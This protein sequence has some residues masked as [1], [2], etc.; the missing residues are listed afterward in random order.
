ML[1]TAKYLVLL[2]PE[3]VLQLEYFSG[4]PSVDG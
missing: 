3:Q 2:N 4:L 1:H